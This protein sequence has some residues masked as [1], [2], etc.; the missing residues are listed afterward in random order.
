MTGSSP[1]I[2]RDDPLRMSPK[3]SP[4]LGSRLARHKMKRKDSDNASE[5][6]MTRSGS[7]SSVDSIDQ[8]LDMRGRFDRVR[9]IVGGL[10]NA[11]FVHVGV[12]Q[13]A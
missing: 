9:N 7:I 8:A 12:Q 3:P 1:Q 2:N 13:G 11:G 5:S 6:P 10:P 4:R